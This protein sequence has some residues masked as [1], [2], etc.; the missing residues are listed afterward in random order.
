M[1]QLN[2]YYNYYTHKA[3]DDAPTLVLVP[4]MNAGSWFFLHA[5][6]QLEESFKLLIINNP[7]IDGAAMLYPLTTEQIATLIIDI[8]AEVNIEN[9]YLLGHSMGSFVAQQLALAIPHRVTKLVLVNS[10]YGQPQTAADI[11]TLVKAVGKDFGT[12]YHELDTDPQHALKV[13]FSPHTIS[14]H[15][16]IF[17]R[18]LQVRDKH[19][20]NRTTSALHL[21][22]GSIFTSYGKL[23]KLTMPTLVVSGKDDLL[24]SAESGLLLA[25]Q[26]KGAL[27][28]ECEHTGH[29]PMLEVDNF[30][31]N[32]ILF[33]N[34]GTV[35]N[36][37]PYK[38]VNPMWSNVMPQ[39]YNPFKFL[40]NKH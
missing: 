28:W 29:F 40:W 38:P 18:F 32:I 27:Y 15:F 8:L 36:N 16:T 33:L 20:V 30:Y 7:G 22:C 1:P 9:F 31:E 2:T 19:K 34:D 5:V 23:D 3:P 37:V 17:S 13:L 21:T 12:F 25:K 11:V 24:V 26:I 14:K 10:S 4:G 6:P 35:G 39:G